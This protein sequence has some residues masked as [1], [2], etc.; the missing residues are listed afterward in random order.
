MSSAR[1]LY[2]T[3]HTQ[4]LSLYPDPE[5]QQQV[6][7]LFEHFLNCSRGDIVRDKGLSE[8]PDTLY[9]ALDELLGGKPIQ[10]IIGK[11]PFYGREFKVTPQVLIPRNETEELV[12][13]IIKEN[14]A[15]NLRILDIGTGTGCIPITL[16]LEMNQATVSALDISDAAL[17]V[18]RENAEHLDA[19]ISYLKVDILHENIPV[20]GIDILVSN[21]PYVR[22][23]EKPQMHQ[24][25]LEHEPELALFVSDE[26]PLI[27]YRTIA[28]KGLLALKP[29]GK[30]YFEINEALGKE[31][32]EMVRDLGYQEVRIHQD[33]QGKDRMLTAKRS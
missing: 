15:P 33:L 22:E 3:F 24:N 21:P 19:K 6:F 20:E 12:H 5:A 10:Y 32:M 2:N 27:F 28:Q 17:E 14:P 13:M 11:A 18:A 1:Q 29:K 4:L 16:F 25:V 9:L 8:I 31:M 7:W 23:L 26:N 30:L